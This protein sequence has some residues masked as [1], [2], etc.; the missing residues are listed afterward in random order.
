MLANMAEDAVKAERAAVRQAE[1]KSARYS[2]YGA[3]CEIIVDD[4]RAILALQRERELAA[5]AAMEEF[6]KAKE[7][8]AGVTRLKARRE[9][10]VAAAS[11]A[12]G[13]AHAAAAAA[14]GSGNCC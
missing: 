6:E 8:K 14:D 11:G 9:V 3:D 13:A 10:S 1:A 7:R 12:S 2:R 5:A 4:E